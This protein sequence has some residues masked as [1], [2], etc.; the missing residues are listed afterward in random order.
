VVTGGRLDAA[1]LA[2]L[3]EQIRSQAATLSTLPR[4]DGG[5]PSAYD[6]SDLRYT[7]HLGAGRT[8]AVSNCDRVIPGGNALILYTDR[9]LAGL[10]EVPLPDAPILVEWSASGGECLPELRLCTRTARIL[11]SGRWDT[12][13]MEVPAHGQLDAATT[14]ALAER[15]RTEVKTLGSLPPATG[16]CPSAYDGSDITFTFRPDGPPVSVSNCT[17]ELDGNPLL[18]Y[19]GELVASLF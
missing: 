13:K 18:D 12:T 8:V 14:A 3:Q 17:R 5:C 16:G 15:I 6:G 11:A 19:T 2:S 1:A 7:Y 10:D 9:L 4:H